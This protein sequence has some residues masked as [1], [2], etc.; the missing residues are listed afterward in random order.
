MEGWYSIC[1]SLNLAR[2]DLWPQ[3]TTVFLRAKQQIFISYSYYSQHNNSNS[4][5]SPNDFPY[6]QF[7]RWGSSEQLHMKVFI[8]K[9]FT[10]IQ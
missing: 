2:H 9:T 5:C 1:L 10:A 4:L 6:V 3:N 8:E 7:V